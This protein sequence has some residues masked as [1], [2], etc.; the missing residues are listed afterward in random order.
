MQECLG[1]NKFL[2]ALPRPPAGPHANQRPSGSVRGAASNGCPYHDHQLAGVRRGSAWRRA[3][4]PFS[5]SPAV[6]AHLC[7]P[8]PMNEYNLLL[9]SVRRVE[10]IVG[11]DAIIGRRRREDLRAPGSKYAPHALY[12]VTGREVRADSQNQVD[13][14]PASSEPLVIQ[15]RITGIQGTLVTV[16]VPDGY[17]GGGEATRS[18]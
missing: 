10:D 17:P 14:Q 3:S 13:R 9:I 4:F 6:N 12:S 15:G 11:T 1:Q 2:S 16:K 8:N 7:F 18:S 5:I